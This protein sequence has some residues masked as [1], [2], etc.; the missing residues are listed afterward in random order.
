MVGNYNIQYGEDT[1]LDTVRFLADSSTLNVVIVCAEDTSDEWLMCAYIYTYVCIYIH[2]DAY[3]TY[4]T[5]IHTCIH[6]AVSQQLN[7]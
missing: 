1:D 5:R 4:V 3:H 2:I 6:A 7:E